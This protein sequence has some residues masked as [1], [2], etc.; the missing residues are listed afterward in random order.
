MQNEVRRLAIFLGSGVVCTMLAAAGNLEPRYTLQDGTVTNSGLVV[1]K[2]GQAVADISPSWG[3]LKLLFGVGA[4][5]AFVYA[6]EKS[7]EYEPVVDQANRILQAQY[8][9]QLEQNAITYEAERQALAP[10]AVAAAE[11][12]AQ[13]KVV[14]LAVKGE[15][16]LS[17][18]EPEPI[19]RKAPIQHTAFNRLISSPFVSRAIFGGQRTGKSYLAACATKKLHAER[20]IKVFHINLCS[21]ESDGEDDSYWGHAKSVRC[22]LA[23]VDMDTGIN[24]IEDAIR[25][26]LEWFDTNNSIM[27]FDEIAYTGSVSNTFAVYLEPLLKI[28]AD[29][30][31]TLASAGSKR[32]LGLW[33][34]APEFTATTLVD[35]AKAVKKLKLCLVAVSPTKSIEWNGD[36][37]KFDAE[38]FSQV[39]RNFKGVTM[40]EITTDIAGCDRI[41]FIDGRWMPVGVDAKT[42]EVVAA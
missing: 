13:R 17:Q 32:K 14:E 5:V 39:A 37:F 7:Y 30:I 15:V 28:F 29:K 38:L 2:S 27:V 8:D 10:V 22:D 41:T 31:S 21:F 1:R 35:D 4:W 33:T 16:G 19:E 34:L 12:V 18:I 3:V 24:K 23:K 11:D 6:L 9:A 40:P 20:G 26:M 42:L 25:L 36:T